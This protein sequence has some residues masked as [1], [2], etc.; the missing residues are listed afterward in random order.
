[1][2]PSRSS[3]ESDAIIADLVDAQF[4][5]GVARI[6]RLQGAL[7]FRNFSRIWLEASELKRNSPPKTLVAR[8]ASAEDPDRR[9]AGIPSE[10]PLEPIRALLEAEGLP[11]PRRYAADPAKGVELLEDLGE[12]SLADLASTA[13]GSELE[14]LYVEACELPPRLQ[15]IEPRHQV[16]NFQR[17]LDA[18]HFRFKA[19][20]FARWSLG[21]GRGASPAEAEVVR[22]AF[23][24]IG[25]V[26]RE[27]PQRLAH[28]DLQSANLH[29]VMPSSHAADGGHTS[30]ARASRF[31]RSA[32]RGEFSVALRP[33]HAHPQGEGPRPVPRRGRG[34]RGRPLSAIPPGDAPLPPE[35]L[36]SSSH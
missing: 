25:L 30:L 35:S 32:R 16:A 1:V 6:E 34:T 5:V 29:V 10:P 24:Q 13:S 20:R 11:V 36:Q 21:G 9:P 33:A 28:R 8:I 23:E 17:R 22:D 14:S 2:N 19:E 31:T 4:G 7:G 26:I 18:A 27:A 3:Q 15:R 12:V